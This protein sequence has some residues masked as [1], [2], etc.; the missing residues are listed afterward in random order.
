MRGSFKPLHNIH[1][2]M[3]RALHGQFLETSGVVEQDVLQMAEITISELVTGDQ[4]DDSDFLARVDLLNELGLP[5]LI[6][7]YVRFFRLRS[8]L[9]QSTQSPICIS[10]SVLDFDSV[11]DA[12]YYAGLEGG[13]LE[14][15]GKL[16]PD[17]THVFV[18]STCQNGNLITLEN[19]SVPEL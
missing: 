14:A 1:L 10:I 2:D 16:F 11:F 12:S 17:N 7:D 19:V 18:Y 5:A 15:L 4:V 13:I 8:W 3:L 9:R 6:S